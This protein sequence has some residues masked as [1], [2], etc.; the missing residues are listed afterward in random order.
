MFKIIYETKKSP[1]ETKFKR[2]NK[3]CSN[4][5]KKIYFYNS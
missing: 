5:G 4:S 3:R 2:C 1:V